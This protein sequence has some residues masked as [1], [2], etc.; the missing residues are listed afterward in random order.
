MRTRARRALLEGASALAGAAL[1]FA[2]SACDRK[3]E[4]SDAAVTQDVTSRLERDL[5][6]GPYDLVVTTRDGV[7]TLSGRVDRE[8]QRL[9]AA[10]IA[11]EAAGVADVVNHLEAEKA[12]GAY[13][14]PD[15]GAPGAEAPPGTPAPAPAEEPS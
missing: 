7:V 15:V 10:R 3:R 8:E 13:R 12:P 4:T 6:L 14:A 1:L 5:E 11:R 2:G 9:D